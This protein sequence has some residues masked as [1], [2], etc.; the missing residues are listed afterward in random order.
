MKEGRV[1][2]I[3]EDAD[4]LYRE[5]LKELE[6]GRIRDAAEKAWGAMVRATKALILVRNGVEI[7]GAIGLTKE[8]IKLIKADKE[9]MEK[10]R[11]RYFTRESSLHGHCF[12]NGLCDPKVEREIR[13]TNL[14]IEDARKL[15]EV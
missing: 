3:F 4:S 1:K 15:A 5:S 12:Y 8:F 13:E 14:Y 6:E 2:E 7:E 10:L 9:V 11:D